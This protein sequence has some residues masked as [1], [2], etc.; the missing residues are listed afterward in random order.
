[1][2]VA[3]ASDL[4]QEWL[5]KL[6]GLIGDQAMLLPVTADTAVDLAHRLPLAV[7]VLNADPP[8]AERLVQY[9]RLIDSAPDAVLLCL[10]SPEVK[11]RL[12]HEQLFTPDYWIAPDAGLTELQEILR[13][14]L[15]KVALLAGNAVGLGLPATTALAPAP[16]E[17][18]T[19]EEGVLRQLLAAMAGSHDV[20]R[21]LAAYVD[22]A[23]QLVRCANHCFL[24]RAPGQE[25]LTVK[26]SMGLPPQL[27][28]HGR[29][30]SSDALIGWY[31]NSCRA[32]TLAE[33]GRWSDVALATA[34]AHELDVFRG[35][36]A[37]PL[38]LRGRVDGLLI[39]G[40][41]VVGEPY[42]SA[43]L[44]TLFVLTGYVSL[45]LENVH[46]Q[47]QVNVTQA[48]MERSLSGMR[49]GLIT[50][51]DDGRIAVCNPYAA[52]LLGKTPEQLEGA[53]LRALPSPL[54]D[55]LY[56]AFRSPEGAITAE[57]VAIPNCGAQLRVTTSTL[58]D[59]VGRTVGSVLLLEDITGPMESAAK[60]SRQDTINVLTSI[61]GRIAHEVRT[62]LTAIK[63]YAQLMDLPDE[64]GE[65]VKF[66]RETVSPELDRLDQLI[67]EQVRLVEQPSPNFQLVDLE[68]LVRDA[69][70]QVAQTCKGT[71][72]PLLKVVPPVPPVVA[73]PGPTRDAISYLLRYLC[74]HS[75]ETVG[76]QLDRTDKGPIPRVRLR[77]RTPLNGKTFDAL[78]I[79]DPLA[80]LQTEEGDLGP[81]I[82]RQLVDKMGGSVEARN[83]DDY[84]EFRV[85]FPVNLVDSASLVK[86]GADAQADRADHR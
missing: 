13:F 19:A 78:T 6:G 44:E 31:R 25:A 20:D 16:A 22:G 53:D 67:T 73:D 50:L 8:T 47:E 83:A 3:L 40:E 28:A 23:C 29:L 43:E 70:K 81:A 62:P 4:S 17:R 37:I 60:S 77:L 46:L 68:V 38:I 85:F 59:G 12:R 57:N 51:G 10:A 21:L 79:L 71:G 18:F 80:A 9:R 76:L 66:W 63:T 58:L 42:T 54:G 39:L 74:E 36:V 1:M 64:N 45:H 11:E 24:W 75:T 5:A 84:F 14:T 52:R 34:L 56:A 7:L 26:A 48:Y 65:L 30:G 82:S 49:C 86:G 15:Q 69:I 35:Q 27:A 41:K 33:L 72:S 55:H 2:V 32:L 61:I